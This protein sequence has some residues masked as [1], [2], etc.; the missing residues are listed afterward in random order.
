MRQTSDCWCLCLAHIISNF[1]SMTRHENQLFASCIKATCLLVAQLQLF[2]FILHI[3]SGQLLFASS[4]GRHQHRKIMCKQ[5]KLWLVVDECLAVGNTTTAAAVCCFAG[6]KWSF[7][8]VGRYF[9][10]TKKCRHC[11][12]LESYLSI[13]WLVLHVDYSS[14]PLYLECLVRLSYLFTINFRVWS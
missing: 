14:P 11:W 4:A 12:L 8:K 10:S 7:F 9:T 3:F 13:K 2:A 6:C 1:R 5:L